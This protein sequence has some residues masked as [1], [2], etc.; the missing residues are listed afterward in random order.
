[1]SSGTTTIKEKENSCDRLSVKE[2]NFQWHSCWLCC[3]Q[4]IV[5]W[6]IYVI[7]IIKVSKKQNCRTDYTDTD[8]QYHNR[9]LY[10]NNGLNDC[11]YCKW[12]SLKTDNRNMQVGGQRKQPREDP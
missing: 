9:Y 3:G 6:K 12:W 7:I 4:V 8:N 5:E 2:R 1:M 10:I 11:V